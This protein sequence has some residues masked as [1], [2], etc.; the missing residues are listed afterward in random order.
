M[1]RGHQSRPSSAR[2]AGSSLTSPH[3][4][5]SARL[6]LSGI[7]TV[8]ASITEVA[9]EASPVMAMGGTGTPIGFDSSEV[10]GSDMGHSGGVIVMV[11]WWDISL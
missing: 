11:P 3:A 5:S 4:D 6:T 10:L 2:T 8:S 9:V 7:E 1:A